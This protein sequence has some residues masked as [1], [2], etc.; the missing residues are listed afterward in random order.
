M[1]SVQ[2]HESTLAP[3]QVQLHT[4]TFIRNVDFPLIRRRAKEREQRKSGKRRKVIKPRKRKV[5]L[6]KSCEFEVTALLLNVH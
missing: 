5:A 6:G 1:A 4:H 3:P 2:E